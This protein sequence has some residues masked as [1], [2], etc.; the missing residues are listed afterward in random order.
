MKNLMILIVVAIVL[1]STSV[2]AGKK[3]QELVIKQSDG[4]TTIALNQADKKFYPF[5]LMKPKSGPFEISEAKDA[6]SV[7]LVNTINLKTFMLKVTKGDA[8]TFYLFSIGKSLKKLEEFATDTT[9]KCSP[10]MYYMSGKYYFRQ[11]HE[12]GEPEHVRFAV[13]NSKLK[14]ETDELVQTS[15]DGCVSYSNYKYFYV[16]A[17]GDLLQV[18]ETGK[19]LKKLYEEP[20]ASSFSEYSLDGYGNLYLVYTNNTIAQINKKGKIG[21]F[22]ISETIAADDCLVFLQ[23]NKNNILIKVR[24]GNGDNPDTMYFC[25]F[26][27]N[28]SGLKL[29][30][31]SEEVPNNCPTTLSAL[32]KNKQIKLAKESNLTTNKISKIRIVTDGKTIFTTNSQ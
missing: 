19:T 24:K 5:K 16:N 1:S 13:F 4:V 3:Y 17:P 28:K 27:I 8:V 22:A 10:R 30:T 18:Y 25:I 2:Y 15:N 20:N 26:S 7:S 14:K 21:P 29:K 11:R 9:D 12:E 31:K 23:F 32:L 6:D